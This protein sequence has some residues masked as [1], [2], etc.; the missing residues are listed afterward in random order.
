[1]YV[2]EL[3]TGWDHQPSPSPTLLAGGLAG[4]VKT[5]RYLD[6]GAQSQ[7]THNHLLVTLCKGLGLTTMN[8]VGNRGSPG[9]LPNLLT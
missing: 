7:Y 4:T 2:N 1:M 3:S 8:Q 5:G 6:Y 9:A